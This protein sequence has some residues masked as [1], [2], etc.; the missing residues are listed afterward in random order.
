MDNPPLISGKQL[1]LLRKAVEIETVDA[2]AVGMVGYQARLWAQVSLPY[3]DPGDVPKWVRRNG[4]LTLVL[5]P[6]LIT[7]RD[8]TQYDAYPY[9]IIPRLLLT[10]M[11][12]E[13]V[14]LQD[15]ELMLGPS[16]AAFM[17]DLGLVRNGITI[18][19][20][21]EQ[22]QRIASTSMIVTD[23]RPNM[24]AGETFTFAE[25]WQL[26]WTPRDGDN[27]M[28]W[29]STITL[30]EKYYQSIIAAPIPIDLRALGALR[31]TG[32]GGLQ[33]DM[34][35][36][37]SHRMSYLR[38]STLVPWVLLSQQFGSQYT[39]IRQ[40]KAKLLVALPKVLAVYPAAKVTPTA[41]GLLLSPSPTPI[42][43]AQNRWRG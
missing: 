43:A 19:R 26:W 24:L 40:F 5:R 1:D 4:S 29:P 33:L 20:L 3:R 28:L 32:G 22:V 37:L 15:R 23:A 18:K 11:A 34:Y 7:L 10:W 6:G 30:S 25:S 17:R 2:K 27:E 41:D 9:G 31:T 21:R 38:S 8:G 12:T 16:L 42:A 14:R 35:T 13:A 36:W 39:H